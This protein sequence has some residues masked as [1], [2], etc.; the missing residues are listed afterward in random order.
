M[1]DATTWEGEL[2]A[3]GD[4]VIAV[5]GTRGNASYSLEVSVK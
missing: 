4:Y 1:D 2:P 3:N 5:G